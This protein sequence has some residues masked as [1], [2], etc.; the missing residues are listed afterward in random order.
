LEAKHCP[1][2]IAQN[3]QASGRP[4][5]CRLIQRQQSK[6]TNQRKPPQPKNLLFNSIDPKRTSGQLRD[7]GKVDCFPIFKKNWLTQS[8]G[9]SQHPTSLVMKTGNV[10]DKDAS[11]L[12]LYAHRAVGRNFDPQSASRADTD[13]DRQ[14]LLELARTWTQAALV[15]RHLMDY[16]YRWS[17]SPET[18]LNQA[19]RLIDEAL[20]LARLSSTLKRVPRRNV[21]SA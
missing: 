9:N 14:G 16:Q 20:V 8:S 10:N 6:R 13:E 5:E 2:N 18:A 17:D 1:Q 19:E 3:F 12:H 7:L 11:G 15:E 4:P 21:I